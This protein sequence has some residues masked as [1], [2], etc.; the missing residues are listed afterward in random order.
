[1]EYRKSK[2]RKE[3]AAD[4]SSKSPLC[5]LESVKHVK[6][7]QKQK[8]CYGFLVIFCICLYLWDQIHIRSISIKNSSLFYYYSIIFVND[9][10]LRGFFLF[11]G[12]DFVVVI[13]SVIKKTTDHLFYSEFFFYM[14]PKIRVIITIKKI[15]APLCSVRWC[16]RSSC[17]SLFF[18][19]LLLLWYK[20]I[21]GTVTMTTTT[22]MLLSFSLIELS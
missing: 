5:A 1:M 7:K 2:A 13:F 4:N 10:V 20:I 3:P 19:F 21:H 22:T 6:K 9:S 8:N 14:K 18:P 11:T 16:R 17:L 12:E 15:V